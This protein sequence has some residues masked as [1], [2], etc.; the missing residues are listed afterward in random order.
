[1][2]ASPGR[3]PVRFPPGPPC[4]RRAAPP[5]HSHL[6]QRVRYTDTRT[7]TAVAWRIIAHLARG[8]PCFGEPIVRHCG[9]FCYVAAPGH[10]GRTPIL[11]YQGSGGRRAIGVYLASS[12]QFTE[13]ELPASFGPAAGIQNKKSMPPLLFTRV[14]KPATYGPHPAPEVQ[15]AKVGHEVFPSHV[16]EDVDFFGCRPAVV[17]CAIFRGDENAARIG[18]HLRGRR[19]L[20]GMARGVEAAS[21]D[22]GG[23]VR[24]GGMP[25]RGDGLGCELKGDGVLD[26]AGYPAEASRT[27]TASTG[28]DRSSR[29]AGR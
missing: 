23:F 12:G 5:G 17:R 15:A 2:A 19:G 9:R 13:S 1:V 7:R 24:G 6:G 11:R 20:A 25:G 14:P 8:R 27:G 21:V 28:P 3:V 26:W 4:C 29:I 10:R 18:E 22:G 16:T